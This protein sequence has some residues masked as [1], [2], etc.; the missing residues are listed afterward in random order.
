MQRCAFYVLGLVFGV[1]FW[2]VFFFPQVPV[3]TFSVSNSGINLSD[4]VPEEQSS[5]SDLM[6]DCRRNSV[7]ERGQNRKVE[8]FKMSEPVGQKIS[9]GVCWKI[10]H[11]SL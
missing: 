8:R 10:V 5:E 9:F 6:N 3:F 2:F 4:L 7:F 11:C 1:L